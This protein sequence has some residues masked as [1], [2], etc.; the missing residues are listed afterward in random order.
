MPVTAIVG[1]NWGDE[2]KGK[3]TDALASQSDYVVRYQ[4]GSNAGHTIINHY[5]KSVLNLLPSGVF[6]PN[7]VNVIGPGV[8]LNIADLMK[9]WHQLLARG[10]PAPNLAVSERAQVL[11]PYHIR[12]DELEEE[13]LGANSFGSTK[14]GIS[15][16]YADKYA[17]LG[18]QVAELYDTERLLSRL[19]AS[20][21]AKNVLLQHL[22]NQPPILAADL[23]PDILH[24]AA[25]LKPFVQDTTTL[26]NEA[27]A[28][29]KTVLVEGQ[30]GSLRDPDHGIY[31]FTT[32]SSTLAGFAAVGAGIPPHQITRVL[33]V[34]KAYSSCVGAGPFVMELA[35][36]AAEEL[37]R[38]GGDAGEFGA[39]T[40]RPRR[41]GWFDAVATRYGCL[42]QGATEVALTNL[43]V[44]GYLDEI[45]ICTAYELHGERTMKFPVMEQLRYAQ[46]V[47]ET[48]P[49]WK[50][51]ISHIRQ[52]TDLPQEA[53]AY[54][55][56]LEELIQTPIRFISNG[57]KREQLMER[58]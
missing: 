10:I 27:L 3:L 18:I 31:P 6:D 48:V 25:F 57:P 36:E 56:L 42:L 50:C 33:A 35:G 24:W 54:I 26:L 11:M 29:G 15:P 16:F 17:K 2:G 28:E 20:L 14:M 53:Q 49:G 43:D 37:R 4:G 46:P 30:L 47:I 51:D 39:R 38:R 32:S 58:S 55:A 9:E 40:G 19:E 22:Y 52:F 34:T 21:A 12:F 45:P 5:G 41:V 13:R 44:L 1:A 7:V 8:A 23:L